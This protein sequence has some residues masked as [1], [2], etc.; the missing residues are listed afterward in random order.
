MRIWV[1]VALLVNVARAAAEPS[2]SPRISALAA[3]PASEDAFWKQLAAEGTPLVEDYV[4]RM[5]FHFTGKLEKFTI[6]LK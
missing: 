6:E 5:P 3:K 4:D 1:I 2:P